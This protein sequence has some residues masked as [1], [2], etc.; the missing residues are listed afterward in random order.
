MSFYI[1]VVVTYGQGAVH[2]LLVLRHQG[3]MVQ[4]MMLLFGTYGQGVREYPRNPSAIRHT[5]H[6]LAVCVQG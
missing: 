1:R 5:V 2:V 3:T 6:S 4:C